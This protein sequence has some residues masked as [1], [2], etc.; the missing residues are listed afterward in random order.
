MKG[1]SF[2]ENCGDTSSSWNYGS[3]KHNL[4]FEKGRV[5]DLQQDL[6]VMDRSV[7]NCQLDT[8]KSYWYSL[9][10]F[11]KIWS[12]ATVPEIIYAQNAMF[13]QRDNVLESY[14]GQGDSA[15]GYEPVREN[16]KQTDWSKSTELYCKDEGINVTNILDS[17][18][19]EI[20]DLEFQKVVSSI[21]SHVVVSSIH[22]HV[23]Q[24][25][26]KERT[27]NCHIVRSQ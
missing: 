12:D 23:E 17:G 1:Q 13:G 9:L 5:Y 16:P 6:T 20:S 18:N 8:N 21:H 7:S 2:F 25:L 22:S 4:T 14:S 11:K 26:D 24:K 3:G 27:G 10:K 15:N 19:C